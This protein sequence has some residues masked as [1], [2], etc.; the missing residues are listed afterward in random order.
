MFTRI[1]RKMV[2]VACAIFLSSP[3]LAQEIIELDAGEVFTHPHSGVVIPASLGGNPRTA[4]YVY[5]EDFLDIGIN[6]QTADGG[7]LLSV[8]IFRNTN[9]DVPLWFAQAQSILAGNN[10]YDDPDL[11]VG[12]QA[13][14]PPGQPAASGL[15]AI[16][17]PG[18]RSPMRSTGVALF[19]VGEWYV[20][21]R[22][23]STTR[24]PDGLQHWM[25][26]A[27]AEL[28]LPAHSA[29]AVSP[30]AD[31]PE[32]LRFRGRARDAQGSA[33]DAAMSS[34]LGGVLGSIVAEQQAESAPVTWC[35]DS[36]V[37]IGQ[38]LYRAN[39][40]E[41]GYLFALGDNGNAARVGPEL[42]LD[43]ISPGEEDEDPRF[44]VMLMTAGRNMNY[45]PQDR[46]PSPQRVI[47]LIEQ[48]RVASASNTWGDDRAIEISAE[49]LKE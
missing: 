37:T 46:L 17:E 45:D 11:I 47:E 44:T 40:E 19:A 48:D 39:A 4:A 49:A 18:E 3:A 30:I 5:A 26:T 31:C 24:T 9:G 35:R 20:K 43:G 28:T 32:P 10:L 23:S 2:A 36:V 41:S 27:L 16:F 29:A 33:V 21:M 12:P 25:E 34:L 7:Q 14:V 38:A 42:R 22:A 13:F 6:F 1:L 8:Y 15:R